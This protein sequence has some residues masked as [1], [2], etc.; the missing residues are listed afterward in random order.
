[1]KLII[2]GSRSIKDPETVRE[3]MQQSEYNWGNIEILVNGDAE[4]VDEI[5]KDLA[6]E[7]DIDIDLHPADDYEGEGPDEMPAPLV[8]NEA[9][10]DEADALLAVWNGSSTGTSHM[11]SVAEKEGLHVNIHRTDISQLDEFF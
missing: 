7:K 1:M 3:A 6:E 4:G 2:A 8:R 9:M 11:I 10:A 5:A